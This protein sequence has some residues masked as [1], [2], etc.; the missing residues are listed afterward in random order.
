MVD[1]DV[2]EFLVQV[3]QSILRRPSLFE[4]M[5][6]SAWCSRRR[7]GTDGLFFFYRCLFDAVLGFILLL[8]L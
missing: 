1:G 8:F 7:S 2:S 4:L 6:S 3:L 5:E